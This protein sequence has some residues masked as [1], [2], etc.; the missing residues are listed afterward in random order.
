MCQL[1]LT[2]SV[3]EVEARLEAAE[4]QQ[5]ELPFQTRGLIKDLDF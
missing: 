2:F 1:L 5:E 3:W 4:E